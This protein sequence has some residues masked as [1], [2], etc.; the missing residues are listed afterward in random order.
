MKKVA[1]QPSGLPYLVSPSE[2]QLVGFRATEMTACYV[3]RAYKGARHEEKENDL[4]SFP[5]SK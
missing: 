4:A 5:A 3:G 1:S 2:T